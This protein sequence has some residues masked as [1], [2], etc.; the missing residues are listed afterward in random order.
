MSPPKQVSASPHYILRLY[1]YL[2]SSSILNVINNNNVPEENLN[3]L[4]LVVFTIIR[5]F[6]YSDSLSLSLSLL[7][8]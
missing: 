8:L 1:L 5:L 7:L 4:V 3:L 2:P 6:Y